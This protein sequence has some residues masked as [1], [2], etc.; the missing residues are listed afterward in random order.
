M[1]PSSSRTTSTLGDMAHLAG[2]QIAAALRHPFEIVRDSVTFAGV[3]SR[4]SRL[5]DL[6]LADIGLTR[7]ELD[8]CRETLKAG[9]ADEA[10]AHLSALR[11]ADAWGRASLAR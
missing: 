10:L 1:R 4:L 2:R 8:D 3:H 6:L 9:G 5:D 11:R 7:P